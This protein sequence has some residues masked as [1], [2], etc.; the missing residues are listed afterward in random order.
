MALGLPPFEHGVDPSK[1]SVADCFTEWVQ[2][3]RT[4]FA[5]TSYSRF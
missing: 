5:G 1:L 3:V 4:S 2:N